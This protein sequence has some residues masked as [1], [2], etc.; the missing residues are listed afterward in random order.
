MLLQQKKGV[1]VLMTNHKHGNQQS[2]NAKA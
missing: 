2:T 1:A